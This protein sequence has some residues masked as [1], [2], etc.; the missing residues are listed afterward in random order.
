MGCVIINRSQL[1]HQLLSYAAVDALVVVTSSVAL[2]LTDVEL[3]SRA[4]ALDMV[5]HDLNLAF[6]KL[7]HSHPSSLPKR[8]EKI[9]SLPF[10]LFPYVSLSCTSKSPSSSSLW[11]CNR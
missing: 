11:T 6:E 3:I 1:H 7:I 8:F 2:S 10:P 4:S 5:H 9:P